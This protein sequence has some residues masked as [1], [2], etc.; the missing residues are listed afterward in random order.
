MKHVLPHKSLKSLYYTLIHS[1]ITYGIHAWGNGNTKKL[2]ILQKRALRIINKKGYRSHTDLL[3]KSAKILKIVDVF[4]LQASLFLYDLEHDLLPK[5]FRKCVMKTSFES[6]KRITRQFKLL[7]HEKPR[8]NLSLK[9]PKHNF[10]RIWNK[11]DKQIRNVNH[12][13]KFKQML[14][15]FYLDIYKSLVIC[16]NPRCQE[17]N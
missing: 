12:R 17:C 5:S 1:H 16:L 4:K 14:R 2:D 11:T 15:V 9:L 10:T 7:V 3:C 6:D 13:L 8:T